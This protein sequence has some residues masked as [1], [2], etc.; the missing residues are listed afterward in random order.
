VPVVLLA[1][2]EVRETFDRLEGA[3]PPGIT[4]DVDRLRG[5]VAALQGQSKELAQQ[6]QDSQDTGEL[7]RFLGALAETHRRLEPI[8]VVG[9][10]V[11]KTEA[12]AKLKAAQAELLAQERIEAEAEREYQLR[13]RALDLRS[14][15]TKQ[16]TSVL[17]NPRT[18]A[19]L[20][21]GAPALV[22][23]WEVLRPLLGLD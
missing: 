11:L 18:W 6:L 15:N 10:D 23:L 7:E 4:P 16:L 22:A 20:V 8:A 21:A 13:T 2:E 9:A 12:D 19:A 17:L 5:H 14:A 3:V 1:S